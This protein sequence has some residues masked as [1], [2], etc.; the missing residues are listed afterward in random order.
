[1]ETEAIELP[2]DP[3]SLTLQED[4]RASIVQNDS[5]KFAEFPRAEDKRWETERKIVRNSQELRRQVERNCKSIDRKQYCGDRVVEIEEDEKC[6]SWWRDGGQTILQF[7]A[8][9]LGKR[10]GIGAKGPTGYV[11]PT[12]IQPGKRVKRVSRG[13][14]GHNGCRRDVDKGIRLKRVD[15]GYIVDHVYRYMDSLEIYLFLFSCLRIF[16]YQNLK[17]NSNLND[18]LQF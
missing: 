16:K 10:G 7:F 6:G 2:N 1:M 4:V 15:N 3:S 11:L 8:K 12:G 13:G 17:R 14:R 5:E 18:I 9:I